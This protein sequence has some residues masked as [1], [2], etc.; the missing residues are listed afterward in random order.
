MFQAGKGLLD[1]GRLLALPCDL[2]ACVEDRSVVPAPEFLPDAGEGGAGQFSAQVH[3]QLAWERDFPGTAVP[4]EIVDGQREMPADR[5]LD[6][7][8]RDRA[9]SPFGEDV[10]ESRRGHR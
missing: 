5:S 10:A 2:L 6:V 7:A 4:L 8:E 1:F 9:V 3:R